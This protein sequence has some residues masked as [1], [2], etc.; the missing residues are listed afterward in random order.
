MYFPNFSIFY[1]TCILICLEFMSTHAYAHE[2]KKKR[3]KANEII[4]SESGRK[5]MKIKR[6]LLLCTC[7]R[8]G[9]EKTVKYKIVFWTERA[10]L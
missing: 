6:L 10:K 9:G 5:K 8:K 1:V 7:E 4:N 3:A 2:S